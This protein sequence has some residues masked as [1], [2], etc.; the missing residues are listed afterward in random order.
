M[1][2]IWQSENFKDF[3]S[4]LN[5]SLE[6]KRREIEDS[7]PSS[8]R[9]KGKEEAKEVFT[10]SLKRQEPLSEVSS[11][12][13]EHIISDAI[14]NYYIVAEETVENLPGIYSLP[15]KEKLPVLVWRPFL[16][17]QLQKQLPKLQYHFKKIHP[18]KLKITTKK[19]PAEH[20]RYKKLEIIPV[21]ETAPTEEKIYLASRKLKDGYMAL[22][23]QKLTGR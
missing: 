20:C 2:R 10:K 13:T 3:L 21:I 15:G 18:G 6:E 14:V 11:N 16:T 22:L 5:A 1:N 17:V 12:D 7:I 19:E 9:H 4:K 8:E 23:I